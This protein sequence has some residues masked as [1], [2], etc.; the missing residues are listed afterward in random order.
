MNLFEYQK[1]ARGTALPG[2]LSLDYLIPGLAGEVGEA[3]EAFLYQNSLDDLASELADINWFLALICE[4]L[5]WEFYEVAF[6]GDKDVTL[7]SNQERIDGLLED[8]EVK[9]GIGEHLD[10]LVIAAGE[11]CS[12]WAKSVRDNKRVISPEKGEKIK[13]ALAD[14]FWI[15]GV[16]ARETGNTVEDLLK[17]NIEKLYG[18]KERGV[19]GGSGNNR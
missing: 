10:N 6:W 17:K 15:N 8:G 4:V 7:E 11:V 16:L 5:Q 13:G 3:Q 14:L 12:A 9:L 2:A 1:L 19:L 18:R